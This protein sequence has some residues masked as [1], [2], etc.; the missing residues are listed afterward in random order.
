MTLQNT[1]SSVNIK[2]RLDF[3]CA[4]FDADGG[5]VANAPHMPVHLGSM[6]DC[7]TAIMAKHPRHAR[8]ATSSSPTRPMTAAR[9]CRTSR[10]SCRCS[11]TAAV[12]RR[13]ARASCRYR[14]HHAGLDAAVL[15]GHLR[16]RRAVRRHPHRRRWAFRRSDHSRRAGTGEWPARNPDQNVADLKAQVAACAQRRGGIAPR[17]RGARPRRRHRLHAPRPGQC[18]GVGAPGDRRADG[19]R[20]RRCRW[21]AA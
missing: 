3:S 9:I 2:E 18:R 14:R 19:R 10:W 15:E 8:R 4:I 6:G 20:V 21:T 11:W 13:L 17:L 1:A 12:L 16:R 7:V 5:L